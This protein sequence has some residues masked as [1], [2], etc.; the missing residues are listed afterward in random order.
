MYLF[1]TDFPNFH[2]LICGNLGNLCQE[3]PIIV[4]LTDRHKKLLGLSGVKIKT[5]FKKKLFFN[6]KLRLKR[7]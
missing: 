1:D 3:K 2:K 7:S 6:R 4:C 5:I